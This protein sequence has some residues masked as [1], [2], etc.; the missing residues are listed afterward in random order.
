MSLRKGKSY[1]SFFRTYLSYP[2]S[3]SAIHC[4]WP[5]KCDRYE[6]KRHYKEYPTFYRHKIPYKASINLITH[7]TIRLIIK[8]IRLTFDPL[9]GELI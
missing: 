7:L 2:M 4:A 3:C 1:L 6:V 9:D 8:H 5:K